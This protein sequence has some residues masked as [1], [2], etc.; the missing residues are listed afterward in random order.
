MSGLNT[1]YRNKKITTELYLDTFLDT[2]SLQ[3]R[4]Y[5]K[6]C[7]KENHR[8]LKDFKASRGFQIDVERRLIF[9]KSCIY[10]KFK[11]LILKK[12]FLHTILHTKNLKSQVI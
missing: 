11:D 5:L 6:W 3:S 12:R 9:V 10:K 4:V 8:F 7:Q 2:L 1:F